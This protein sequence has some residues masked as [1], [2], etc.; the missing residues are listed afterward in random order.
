M[1]AIVIGGTAYRTKA[2]C[3]RAFRTLHFELFCFPIR[4]FW[5]QVGGGSLGLVKYI[6]LLSRPKRVDQTNYT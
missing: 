1:I 5:T 2:R 3:L 4:L 6:K